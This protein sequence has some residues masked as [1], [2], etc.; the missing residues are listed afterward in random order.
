MLFE[1]LGRT[2]VLFTR[3]RL[4][5]GSHAPLARHHGRPTGIRRCALRHGLDH[6][7]TGR[8]RN[9]HRGLDSWDLG[10][11]ARVF[12][13][14]GRVAG[15]VAFVPHFRPGSVWFYVPARPPS[16]TKKAPT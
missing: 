6:Q 3:G 16:E 14:S 15:M 10:I 4:T 13:R 8:A 9:H 5:G 12:T 7:W 11:A 1:L 2:G